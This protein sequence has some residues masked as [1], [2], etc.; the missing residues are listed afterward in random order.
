MKTNKYIDV[1]HPP[2]RTGIIIAIKATVDS[3]YCSLTLMN[4]FKFLGMQNV[5]FWLAKITLKNSRK[6]N[7]LKLGVICLVPPTPNGK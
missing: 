4:F 7:I 1:L 5:P 6:D 3:D 2:K